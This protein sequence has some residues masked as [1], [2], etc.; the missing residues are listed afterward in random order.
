MPT[1]F[2]RLPQLISHLVNFLKR[3]VRG[4]LDTVEITGLTD[5]LQR[6]L[7]ERS[8]E[9]R[10][11]ESELARIGD[12]PKRRR[13]EVSGEALHYLAENMQKQLLDGDPEQ[14]R[15]V[16]RQTLV[17]VE[18]KNQRLGLHYVTPRAVPESIA[19]INSVPPWGFESL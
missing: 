13:V 18:L 3:A 2:H 15:R 7:R 14:V 5:E 10:Q 16:V 6:R 11:I 8:L 9:V 12:M 4:L 17:R 1:L 19:C